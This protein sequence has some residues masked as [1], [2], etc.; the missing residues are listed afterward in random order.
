MI[1]VTCSC[2]SEFI[3]GGRGNLVLHRVFCVAEVAKLHPGCVF[4]CVFAFLLVASL[5]CGLWCLCVRG[6][7][8]KQSPP[9]VTFLI[10]LQH[11]ALIYS[12]RTRTCWG[13]MQNSVTIASSLYLGTWD[14]SVSQRSCPLGNGHG[15]SGKLLSLND[16]SV[17]FM[18]FC[19]GSFLLLY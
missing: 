10:P 7:T 1:L 9:H 19:D 17:L 14:V 8:G 5:C 15:V 12:I 2:E 6:G 11:L 3:S 16:Q 13:E 18:F 4:Q